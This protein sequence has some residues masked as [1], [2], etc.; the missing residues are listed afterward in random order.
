LRRIKRGT[1]LLFKQPR[2]FV[3]RFLGPRALVTSVPKSG[4]N[5]LVHTLTLFPQLSFDGTTVRLSE[6]EK[7]HRISK[8]RRGCVVS[9]HKSK[10]RELDK[11]L[12]NKKI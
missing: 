10:S 6:K 11:I 4:T 3:G 2:R 1:E 9:S 12:S 5:L 7:Y 8:I